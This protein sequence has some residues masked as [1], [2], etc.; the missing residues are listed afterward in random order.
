MV[1]TLSIVIPTKDRAT[2]CVSTVKSILSFEQPLE[3]IVQDSSETDELQRQ[4]SSISD[5][6]LHY[7]RVPSTLNMT[8]NFD[9]ALQLATGD[10]VLMLGDDDG[11]APGIFDA[12]DHCVRLDADCMSSR[13]LYASYN[14][15]DF[16]SKYSGDAQAGKLSVNLEFDSSVEEVS[17]A[18][19][20]GKFL[21]GAGQ[22]SMGLP[23][24]YHGLVSQRLI[25]KIRESY[26][27]C[28]FGVSPDVSFSFMAG[29]HARRHLVANFPITIA[30]A[31]G[32]SNAG[33]S[34]LRTHKGELWDDPHMKHYK[35]EAWPGEVPEFFSVE[36]VWAQATLAAISKDANKHYGR[37]NFGR[38]YALM[39]LNHLD[40]SSRVSSAIQAYLKAAKVSR[41]LFYLSLAWNGIGVGLGH[42]RKAVRTI[43]SRFVRP[44]TSVASAV[45][46]FEA[47]RVLQTVIKGK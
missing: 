39:Y 45:D 26:G 44:D 10:Y 28:F 5:N 32:K 31:S 1:N 6:R 15:P 2:Y 47:S 43:A 37:F 11:I 14:W 7:R 46:I 23:K 17:L 33:R 36:S 38:L 30:G 18:R 24:I 19:E 29:I 34:A 12:V 22:G 8:E 9:T 16:R 27:A 42:F 40:Q 21:G 20:V 41:P 25:R 3:L 13:L 4:L 35:G